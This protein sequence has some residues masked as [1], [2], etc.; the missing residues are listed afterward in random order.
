MSASSSLPDKLPPSSH[1]PTRTRAARDASESTLTTKP[2]SITLAQ[3]QIPT[4]SVPSAT[5]QS[6]GSAHRPGQ[7]LSAHTSARRCKLGADAGTTMTWK[8]GGAAGG[9]VARRARSSMRRPVMRMLKSIGGAVARNRAVFVCRL[10]WEGEDEDEDEDDEWIVFGWRCFARGVGAQAVD[11]AFV[12]WR[13]RCS[14]G[15]LA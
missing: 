2:S 7:R 5:A 6:T 12:G 13:C 11:V 15:V 9:G 14:R 10:D 3:I 1:R 8:P 4:H